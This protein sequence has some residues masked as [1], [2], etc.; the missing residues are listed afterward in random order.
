MFFFE[1]KNQKTF[2]CSR[3]L[4]G[5]TLAA[6]PPRVLRVFLLLFLQKEKFLLASFKDGGRRFAFPPYGA[7]GLVG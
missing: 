5:Q 6:Q 3:R 7:G 2:G 1:K 4:S